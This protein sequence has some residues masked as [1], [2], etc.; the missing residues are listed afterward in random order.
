MNTVKFQ[1]H[2]I[3]IPEIMPADRIMEAAKQLK[4]AIHQLPKDAPMDTLE[5][6][7]NL[8]EKDNARW[9]T[10]QCSISKSE[11][12]NISKGDLRGERANKDKVQD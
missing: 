7:Q 5:V 8:L 10:N 2:A 9:E 11:E 3:G 6:L 12:T 4:S 1:H